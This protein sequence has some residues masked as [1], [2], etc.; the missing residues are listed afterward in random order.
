MKL[1]KSKLNAVI[2]AKEISSATYE[3]YKH[4]SSTKNYVDSSLIEKSNEWQLMPESLKVHMIKGMKIAI[5]CPTQDDSNVVMK[6]LGYEEDLE[7]WNVH[8]EDTHIRCDGE[9]YDTVTTCIKGGYIIITADE[10]IK[11]NK[12]YVNTKDGYKVYNA[13]T[14][15]YVVDTQKF[16]INKTTIF[17][18]TYTHLDNPNYVFFAKLHKAEEYLESIKPKFS[19]T[20]T[21]DVEITNPKQIL[22]HVNNS[23]SDFIAAPADSSYGRIKIFST[24]EKAQEFIDN[25]CK[26]YSKNELFNITNGILYDTNTSLR[27]D[28]KTF[29]NYLKNIKL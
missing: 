22:Y 9:I 12:L 18:C 4:N 2:T 25:N 20:T 27:I 21:D 1:Y 29:E 28:F 13:N 14:T 19:F 15:L 10:F 7:F 16:T 24:L 23:Y 26:K 11:A 5:H 3:I 8:K 17:N 6:I